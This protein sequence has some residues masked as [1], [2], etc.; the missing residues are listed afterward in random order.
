MIDLCHMEIFDEEDQIDDGF[1]F[2]LRETLRL[3]GEIRAETDQKIEV[4]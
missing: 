1:I 2:G 3:I 4:K